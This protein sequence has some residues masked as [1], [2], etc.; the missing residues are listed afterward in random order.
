MMCY[1]N[2]GGVDTTFS[3][4]YRGYSLSQLSMCHD[5]GFWWSIFI[6]WEVYLSNKHYFWNNLKSNHVNFIIVLI[7]NLFYHSKF[8]TCRV[9]VSRH[10]LRYL[11]TNEAHINQ[12]RANS[13]KGWVQHPLSVLFMLTC[14][15]FSTLTPSPPS[16]A[17]L[18]GSS[19]VR[20]SGWGRGR[21]W[22]RATLDFCSVNERQLLHCNLCLPS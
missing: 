7:S 3:H 4:Y 18:P 15:Q 16:P 8:R 19:D 6:A 17:L 13:C 5:S 10:G 9:W 2:F 22:L 21:N 11:P 14:F 1:T 12:W 20:P